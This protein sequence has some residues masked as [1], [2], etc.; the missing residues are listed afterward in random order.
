[1]KKTLILAA[2]FIIGGIFTSYTIADTG[3]EAAARIERGAY[4][5][6]RVVV[7]STSAATELLPPT[8]KRADSICK[9]YSSYTIYLGSAAAGTTLTLTGLPLGASE[10]FKLD[11]SMTGAL[12][13]IGAAGGTNISFICL[14]GMSYQ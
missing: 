2:A 6:S 14:D 11:G 7:V 12:Y 9:N 5:K 8:R 3:A 1:M 13:G 10:Y 4:I